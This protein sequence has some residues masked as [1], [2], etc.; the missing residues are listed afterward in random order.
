MLSILFAALLTGCVS[1]TE[2]SHQN[3]VNTMQLQVGREVGDPDLTR[4]R[5]RDR[6]VRTSRLQNGNMEEEYKSGI[7]LR[8][9]TFFEIDTKATKVVGWRYEGTRE[10]CAIVL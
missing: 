9:R 3:F 10:D 4:N 5:Y 8:C 6:L 7:G 2:R 1:P